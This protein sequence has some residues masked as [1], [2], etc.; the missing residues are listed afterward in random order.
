[1]WLRFRGD[2][3]LTYL[4]TYFKLIFYIQF[5][6]VLIHTYIM[7]WLIIPLKLLDFM[8]KT[9]LTARCHIISTFSLTPRSQHHFCITLEPL[10]K[11]HYLI[12]HWSKWASIM[13]QAVSKVSCYCLFFCISE[14]TFDKIYKTFLTPSWQWHRWARLRKNHMNIGPK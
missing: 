5:S 13:E 3:R 8:T 7:Y 14:K 10:H 11:N 9:A 2:I 4:L 1:M 12:I 6:K